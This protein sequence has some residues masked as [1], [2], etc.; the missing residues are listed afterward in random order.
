MVTVIS[1]RGSPILIPLAH[2]ARLQDGKLVCFDAEGRRLLTF[3]PVDVTAYAIERPGWDTLWLM[4]GPGL[5]LTASEPPRSSG[6][7]WRFPARLRF[8]YR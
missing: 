2:D 5:A 7:Q 4:G 1:A 6:P 3:D 8:T